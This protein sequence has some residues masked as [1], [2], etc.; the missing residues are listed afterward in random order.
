MPRR[1]SDPPPSSP[2]NAQG[3]HYAG[4]SFPHAPDTPYGQMMFPGMHGMDYAPASELFNAPI[5]SP[6]GGFAM[7]PATPSRN[8]PPAPGAPPGEGQPFGYALSPKGGSGMGDLFSFPPT[9]SS[10]QWARQAAAAA[11]SGDTMAEDA[12]QR[13]NNSASH[14]D[15]D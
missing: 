8:R 12:G 4:S 7:H 11:A 14:R 1:S 10:S 9:P 5:H 2:T 3:Q 6:A 13:S 15:G